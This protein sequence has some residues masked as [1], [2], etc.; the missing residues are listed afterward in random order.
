MIWTVS[1]VNNK[2][3]GPLVCPFLRTTLQ[4][5]IFERPN[6]NYFLL[7]G[8]E[9]L[10][11]ENQSL[12]IYNWLSKISIIYAAF[13]QQD[14]HGFLHGFIQIWDFKKKLSWYG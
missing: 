10:N 4:I 13:D 9:K 5:A 12:W 7:D 6:H 1:L 8:K 11:V 14:L 2:A 3:N